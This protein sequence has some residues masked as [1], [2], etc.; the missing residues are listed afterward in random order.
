MSK[1]YF[2]FGVGHYHELGGLNNY[3]TVIEAENE[4]AASLIM[5]QKRGTKWSMCYDSNDKAGI[6]R[7][8]LNYIP[9]DKLTSQNSLIP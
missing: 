8:E 4:R 6:E 3:Y 9:F 7:W 1:F 2:T 5:R